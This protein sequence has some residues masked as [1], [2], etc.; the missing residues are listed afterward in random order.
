M[1]SKGI[2]S[3]SRGAY[4]FANFAGNLLLLLM[5]SIVFF[6]VFCRYVLHHSLAWPEETS[7]ILIVWMSLFGASMGLKDRGH[8][9]T[10]AFLSLLP[11]YARKAMGIFID[12]LAGFFGG[13]L[14][15]F[16]WKISVFVGAGQR[17]VYWGIPYFYLYLSLS[18]GGLLLL[19]QAVA[20]ISEDIRRFRNPE[21]PDAP[22]ADLMGH[23]PV[24]E[25]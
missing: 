18:V 10:A 24:V 4:K 6:G 7:M 14:L 9:G 13:Y 1:R 15:V 22:S 17:T 16:G 25:E 23:G 2:E 3:L 8:V 11:E 12:G 5:F 19:I 21:R 20:L